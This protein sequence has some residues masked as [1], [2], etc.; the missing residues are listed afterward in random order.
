MKKKIEEIVKQQMVG[1]VVIVTLSIVAISVVWGAAML[2]NGYAQTTKDIGKTFQ[3][4]MPSF[5][6]EEAGNI[7]PENRNGQ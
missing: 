2:I 6:L 7:V 5:H 1:I 3:P 4:S